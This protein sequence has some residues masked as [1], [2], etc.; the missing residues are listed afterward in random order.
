MHPIRLRENTALSNRA[1]G[2]RRRHSVAVCLLA[3]SALGAPLA[4]RADTSGFPPLLDQPGTTHIPGKFVFSELV[5]P[6]LA[7]AE[8]FYGAL[9]GWKFRDIPIQRLHYAEALSDGHNVAGLIE[10]PLPPGSPHKPDWLPFISAPETDAAVAAATANGGHVL[11]PA[12]DIAGFGR[13]A[14]LADPNGAVFAVLQSTG[15]DPADA[16]TPPD[17]FIWSSLLTPDPE[18][19][20]AFYGKLFGYTPYPAPDTNGVH[21]LIVAD[22]TYSRASINPLPTGLPATA[23]ARW[24]RFVR[25]DDAAAVAAKAASLGGRVLVAPHLDREGATVAVLA[26]PSGAVFGVLEWPADAP[27]ETAK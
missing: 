1:S 6:D 26:D 14:V 24:L 10:R 16:E 4:A 18:G 13:E 2:R 15:G 22:G 27:A 25:V 5:T 11:F 19:A 3:G 20:A 8:R 23:A 21:H 12:R 17:D 7:G 9:F